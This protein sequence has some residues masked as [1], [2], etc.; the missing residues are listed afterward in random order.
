MA[1][2]RD[3]G[4]RVLGQAGQRSLS[5]TVSRPKSELNRPSLKS[6]NSK[7]G[8]DSGKGIDSLKNGNNQT[9]PRKQQAIKLQSM[10]LMVDNAPDLSQTGTGVKMIGHAQFSGTVLRPQSAKPSKSPYELTKAPSWHAGRSAGG[11]PPPSAPAGTAKRPPSPLAATKPDEAVGAGHPVADPSCGPLETLPPAPAA[12]LSSA[13]AAADDAS[14][15]AF[16]FTTMSEL[17]EGAAPV[18]AAGKTAIISHKSGRAAIR[19]GISPDMFRTAF[20]WNGQRFE[21]KRSDAEDMERARERFG[22]RSLALRMQAR[23][24]RDLESTLAYM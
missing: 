12:R 14:R 17:A 11:R 1:H 16:D 23:S 22:F 6:A 13:G 20:A 8:S 15:P 9:Q 24:R 4:H 2:A 5:A 18:K 3:N 21:G 10:Q 7:T 19:T